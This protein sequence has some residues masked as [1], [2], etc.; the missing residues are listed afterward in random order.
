MSIH[1]KYSN[2]IFFDKIKLILLLHVK[3]STIHLTLLR[4]QTLSRHDRGP[5]ESLC[6][7]QSD[8]LIFQPSFWPNELATMPQNAVEGCYFGFNWFLKS[9]FNFQYS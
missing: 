2:F 9:S 8:K 4:K 1:Y 7:I 6:D 5:F 3:N